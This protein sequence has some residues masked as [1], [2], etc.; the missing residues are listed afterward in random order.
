ML[1]Q[2]LGVTAITG[3]LGTA[4][5]AGLASLIIEWQKIPA[6]EG[7]QGLFFFY[8]LPVG[9]IAGAIIGFVTSLIVTSSFWK[10]QGVAAAALLAASIVAAVL[11][12]YD[13]TPRTS[14]GKTYM[15]V[16]ELRCPKG[17]NLSNKARAELG[18]AIWLQ[19]APGKDVKPVAHGVVDFR[20]AFDDEPHIIASA[21]AEQAGSSRYMRLW[22]GDQLDLTVKAPIPRTPKPEHQQWTE[23]QT[24]DAPGGP[25][26]YR[27]RVQDY[28]EFEAQRPDTPA[29]LATEREKALAAVK[30]PDATLKDWLPLFIG[31]NRSPRYYTW[32]DKTSPE[33]LYLRAHAK[34]LAPF[35]ES[36]DLEVARLA[37]FAANSFQEF[38]RELVKPLATAGRHV[39][40]LI[41]EA[42]DHDLPGDPDVAGDERADTFFYVWLAAIQRA[43]GGATQEFRP[44]LSE[45]E[46]AAKERKSGSIAIS[47]IVKGASE[48]LA[49]SP[50]AGS[51]K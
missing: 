17:W 26:S 42:R 31:E 35:L 6:R 24:A 41:Q 12:H 25:Y 21:Y 45:I 33:L 15:L 32:D 38:P 28:D 51:S 46:T 43:G 3:I 29:V 9:L 1:F 18:N 4:A 44:I 13:D 7:Q 49:K 23:W 47:V 39:L 8:M 48:E 5:A 20:G 19:P 37:V 30:R 11:G 40:N 16:M 14:A 22:L 2:I 34:E 50:A 10:A 36:K 27:F